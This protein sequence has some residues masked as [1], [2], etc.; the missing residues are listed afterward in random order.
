MPFPSV[1]PVYGIF[2]AGILPGIDFIIMQ[3]IPRNRAN[4]FA[5]VRFDNGV[6][7]VRTSFFYIICNDGSCRFTQS[8]MGW[9]DKC[10][11]IHSDAED[12]WLKDLFHLNFTSISLRPLLVDE[13]FTYFLCD[14][15]LYAKFMRICRCNDASGYRRAT[16]SVLFDSS[17]DV[18]RCALSPRY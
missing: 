14:L 16:F 4:E 10:R 18:N 9:N 6:L 1:T 7:H 3:R 8:I 5:F 13:F 17:W 11:E 15:P 2:F 12:A